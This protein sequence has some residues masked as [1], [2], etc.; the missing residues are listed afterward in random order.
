MVEMPSS[1]LLGI[2]NQLITAAAFLGGFAATYLGTLLFGCPRSRAG[3]VTICLSAASACCFIVSVLALAALTIQLRPDAPTAY[4]TAG[5]IAGARVLGLLGF[6]AG[7][8]ALLGAIGLGGWLRSRRL[9]LATTG[10]AGA[11]ILF[12]SWAM[13][14]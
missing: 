1:Y 8:Y 11:A 12:C 3:S 7:I 10:M 2:A 6:V 13:I 4:A 14:S 5:R 9:G